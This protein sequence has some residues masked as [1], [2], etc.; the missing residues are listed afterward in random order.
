[1]IDGVWVWM[2]IDGWVKMGMENSAV[3]GDCEVGLTL[4]LYGKQVSSNN[5]FLLVSILCVFLS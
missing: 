5:T 2:G 3:V 4:V 1:M